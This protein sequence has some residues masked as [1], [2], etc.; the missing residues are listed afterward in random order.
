MRSKLAVLGVIAAGILA[1]TVPV[2]GHHSGAAVFDADKPIN[3]T[4]V[5]TR[6]EWVNPGPAKR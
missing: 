1:A 4:G 3:L 6:V 2:E 5:V